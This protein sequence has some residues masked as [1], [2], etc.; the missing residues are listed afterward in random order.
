MSSID[1][2]VDVNVP[3]RTAYNQWTQFESFPEFMEGVESVKQLGDTRTDWVVEIGGVRR[4]FTAEIT[5]QH[6]DERVA[7]RSLDRP[8]QAGVVT[9]HRLNEDN[10]RVTLQMEYDPEGFAEKAA[11]ALQLVRLRVRG[12]LERFKSFI[13]S[14][15]GE[16]GAWRGE[17]PGPHQQGGTG[18]GSGSGYDIGEPMPPQPVNPEYPRETPLPAPGPGPVPPARGTNPAPGS[19]PVPPRDT[20]GP[21]I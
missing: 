1:H 3:I 11:D 12:D 19:G 5:E 9:F 10:T 20:P 17:V 21:V 13:E 6:P 8:R 15:G 14:R 4:E 18:T 16:T 2:S 7:W